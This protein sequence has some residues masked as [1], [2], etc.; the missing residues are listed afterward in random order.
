[1]F[2]C[3]KNVDNLITRHPSIQTTGEGWRISTAVI[4]TAGA[5]EPA[6]SSRPLAA[7]SGTWRA[8]GLPTLATRRTSPGADAIGIQGDGTWRWPFAWLIDASRFFGR[9]FDR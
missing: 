2:D 3:L 5:L 9:R 8:G 4:W 1:V 6:C 7:M